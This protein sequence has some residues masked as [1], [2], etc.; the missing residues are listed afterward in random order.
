MIKNSLDKSCLECGW[1]RLYGRG[2][3]LN[4]GSNWIINKTLHWRNHLNVKRSFKN[5]EDP[6]VEWYKFTLI[7][8][9][10][11]SQLNCWLDIFKVLLCIEKTVMLCSERLV[12]T[13]KKM[14]PV[15]LIL[16]RSFSKYFSFSF[17]WKT[18]MRSLTW[19]FYLWPLYVLCGKGICSYFNSQVIRKPVTHLVTIIHHL[20][21]EISLL[22][23]HI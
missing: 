15:R 13:T 21:F 7:K 20:T 19:I 16:T 18:D 14:I 22:T 12:T 1:Q 17:S 4:C 8:V 3:W 10:V 23:S 11:T 6:T 9:K 2:V 5:Q